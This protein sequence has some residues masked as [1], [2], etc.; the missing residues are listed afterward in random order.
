VTASNDAGS[1]STSVSFAIVV[2]PPAELSYPGCLDS[3]CVEAPATIDPEL[4]GCKMLAVF[5]VEPS[6][7][8]GFTLDTSTGL[9]A[10]YPAVVTEETTYTVTVTNPSGSSKAE[11]R[12]EVVKPVL[13][14]DLVFSAFAEQIEAITDIAEIL[15]EPS[16]VKQFGDW[17]IWMVHRAHLDD[18]SLTEINF[19]NVS[20]PPPH[21]EE[22]I[23]P[24]L[25]KAMATNT[26]IVQLSLA[27][28]NLMKPQGHQLAASLQQNKTIRIVN[29]ECNFLDS[30]A[31]K[32]I[33][34][35]LSENPETKLQNLHV[36]H[37][38]QV[39]RFFGRPVEEM[40][41][42]LMEKNMTI[43]KLGMELNDAHWRNTIDRFLLRNNDLDRRRRK[44]NI[45][46]EEEVVYE[47]KTLSRLVLKLPPSKSVTEVFAKASEHIG[48]F[49]SFVAAH[50]ELPTGT[51][52]QAAAKNKGTPLKYSQVAP[53]IKECR[54]F[55]LDGAVN[56]NVTVADDFQV[57]TEGVMKK[58]SETN[59]NWN[60]DI[61]VGNKRYAYKSSKEPA[62]R[63]S[64]EW[65]AWLS[66]DT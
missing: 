43:I 34:E 33:A 20:M 39:G 46:V 64:D 40:F 53:L 4:E 3:Y 52:L 60:L 2:P 9:I 27:N 48:V 30:A 37:Q 19:N 14:E 51:Q 42:Q 57:D 21:I 28:S 66:T 62:F 8:E 35:K 50:K 63:V 65:A 49:L 41:G 22:R 56:T 58:W 25:V 13:V 55:M 15:P 32:E 59:G 16:K 36:A 7:P 61:A 23:A 1:T 26:H 45:D 10:G 12:F 47:D 29:V 24:K 54:G 18:P 44:S 38:K 17:M 5:S 31:V 6:L 11:I